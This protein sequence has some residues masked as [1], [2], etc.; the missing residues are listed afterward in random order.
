MVLKF[1]Y[2]S[3]IL[4]QSQNLLTVHHLC[5]NCKAKQQINHEHLTLNITINLFIDVKY[6]SVINGWLSMELRDLQD[7]NQPN[8]RTDL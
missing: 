5:D 7:E 3:H 4:T 6:C 1:I 2:I 8:L